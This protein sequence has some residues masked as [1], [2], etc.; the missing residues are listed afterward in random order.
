MDVLRRSALTDGRRFLAL[1]LLA[2]SVSAFV[3][4][5]HMIAPSADHVIAVTPCPATNELARALQA[6]T[7][8]H[9]GMSHAEMGHT[10]SDADDTVPAAAQADTDCAFSALTLAATFPGH[11]DIENSI[12]GRGG[13]TGEPPDDLRIAQ[14]DYLRPP[15]RAPPVRA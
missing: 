1:I 14:R 9:A 2:L 7:D 12:A 10:Q 5:G 11:S 8:H 15:L 6:D 4:A 3:P 13:A